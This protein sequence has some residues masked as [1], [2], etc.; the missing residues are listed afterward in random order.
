[1]AKGSAV[2]RQIDTSPY[3]DQC[4]LLNVVVTTATATAT[5]LLLLRAETYEQEVE[6]KDIKES[7]Q[8]LPIIQVVG[9]F[10]H[11]VTTT[12]RS[13]LLLTTACLFSPQEKIANI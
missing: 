9:F 13:W 11:F 12:A 10:R 1:M 3:L 8:T 2:C 7:S 5:A 6:K 4:Y